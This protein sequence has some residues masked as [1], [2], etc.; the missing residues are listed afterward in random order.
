MH[1]I[2][3]FDLNARRLFDNVII[4]DS[5][6]TMKPYWRN[7][8][9]RKI[10]IVCCCLARRKPNASETVIATEIPE[11]VCFNRY[12]VG[13]CQPPTNEQSVSFSYG[14]GGWP[15]FAGLL[16]CVCPTSKFRL[17]INIEHICFVSMMCL[18]ASFRLVMC[19]CVS[20]CL[21]LSVCVRVCVSICG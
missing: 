14:A 19:V 1:A 12:D 13:A 6:P 21:C 2:I 3:R 16:S 17:D 20:V 15:G 11:Y 8:N 7:N 10:A 4:L 9:N 18:S 5:Y